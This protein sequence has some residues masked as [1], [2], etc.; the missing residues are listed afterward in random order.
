[1]MK[2][3]LILAAFGSSVLMS[4]PASAQYY[5]YEP[6]YGAWGDNYAASVD[7]GR[8]H[9]YRDAAR[10]AAAYGDYGAA[11]YYAHKSRAYGRRSEYERRRAYFGY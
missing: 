7:G 5:G 1:M 10:R 3:A 8:S 11:E 9:A 2:T 6:G 4:A